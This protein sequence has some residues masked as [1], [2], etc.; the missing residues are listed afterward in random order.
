MV[1]GTIACHHPVYSE[2]RNC[3]CVYVCARACM[4][5]W[6]VNAEAGTEIEGREMEG[7][8]GNEAKREGRWK[9]LC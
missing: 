8:T 6:P 1:S 5:E 7:E 4:Q 9:G 3:L 2:E